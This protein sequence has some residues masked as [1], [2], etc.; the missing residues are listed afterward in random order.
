MPPER[1]A[2]LQAGVRP[3]GNISS[4]RA[5]SSARASRSSVASDP[6]SAKLVISTSYDHGV[7]VFRYPSG[8]VEVMRTLKTTD[9]PTHQ[10]G[11]RG[12]GGD[13]RDRTKEV[14]R[15][16]ATEFR[17]AALSADL[18]YMLTT[19]YRTNLTDYAISKGHIQAVLRG[20]RRRYS[21]F[22]YVGAPEMQKRGAWHWHVLLDRRLD[23]SEVR[24][25]WHQAGADGTIN[26]RYFDDPV[27]GALYAAKYVRKGFGEFSVPGVR[28]LRSRNIDVVRSTVNELEAFEAL[29]RAGW[30]GEC[31]PLDTGGWWAASWR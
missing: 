30:T 25:L 4:I 17:R 14:A 23:H 16:A 7:T 31:F 21:G 11:P 5:E 1:I 3:P 15:R 8:A 20:L 28:Y 2:R 29:Q 24:K 22:R 10:S 26:L 13:A 18:R 9:F 19:T 27:K 6:P 12:E